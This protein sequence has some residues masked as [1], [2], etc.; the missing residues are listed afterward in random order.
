MLRN[1]ARHKSVHPAGNHNTEEIG[2]MLT[3]VGVPVEYDAEPSA[4]EPASPTLIC[5]SHLRWGF[6]FQRPQHLMSRFARNRRV[7][8]IE[9]PVFEDSE[10]YLRSSVCTN[11]GVR[12]NTPVLPHGLSQQQITDCQATLLTKMLAQNSITD[13]I[14]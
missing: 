13:Y 2:K 1:R 12:V 4:S 8:F 11:T 5:L 9:E 10:L 6:V 7:F 14:A 3:R